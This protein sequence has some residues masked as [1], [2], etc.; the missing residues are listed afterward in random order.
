MDARDRF[1]TALAEL[2]STA[3]HA[4]GDVYISDYEITALADEHAVPAVRGASCS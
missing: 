2:V 3:Y 1:I 4:Q